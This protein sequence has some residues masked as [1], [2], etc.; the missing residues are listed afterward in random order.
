MPDHGLPYHYLLKAT[1]SGE[2]NEQD[3]P[4]VSCSAKKQ[5]QPLQNTRALKREGYQAV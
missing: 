3:E 2:R 5:V 1:K 4:V